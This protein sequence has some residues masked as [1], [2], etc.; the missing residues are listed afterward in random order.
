MTARPNPID[1][2]AVLAE[3]RPLM[4]ATVALIQ[5]AIRSIDINTTKADRK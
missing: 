4:L 3:R 1:L 5:N 2:A